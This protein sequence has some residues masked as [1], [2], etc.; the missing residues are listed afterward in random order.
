MRKQS[1]WGCNFPIDVHA[2]N[3]WPGTLVQFYQ[4]PQECS[5]GSIPPPPKCIWQRVINL[6]SKKSHEDWMNY[7]RLIL[8]K[9]SL[10]LGKRLL[11]GDII[12]PFFHAYYS[13]DDSRAADFLEMSVQFRAS[14]MKYV[15]SAQRVAHGKSPGNTLRVDHSCSGEDVLPIHVP[16]GL[17][18]VDLIHVSS[19]ETLCDFWIHYVFIYHNVSQ[20]RLYFSGQHFCAGWISMGST[21]SGNVICVQLSIITIELMKWPL[22]SIRILGII[23]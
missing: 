23:F 11:P 19:W 9:W 21:A 18:K 17:Q 12:T 14:G 6:F 1:L 3:D 8:A 22:W 20:M 5:W 7:F 15:W 2:I 16:R 13:K 10:K 4:L